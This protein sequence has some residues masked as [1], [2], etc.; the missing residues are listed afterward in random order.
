[1]I[2]TCIW[3]IGNTSQNIIEHHVTLRCMHFITHHECQSMTNSCNFH[4][5]KPINIQ[6][7]ITRKKKKKILFSMCL[8]PPGK[9]KHLLMFGTSPSL[10]SAVAIKHANW[11]WHYMAPIRTSFLM[12]QY[13]ALETLEQ[14]VQEI[15]ISIKSN[16]RQHFTAIDEVA[17]S[18]CVLHLS[19]WKS[20]K[21]HLASWNAL[22]ITA[23]SVQITRKILM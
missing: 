18:F 13:I 8:L 12:H 15:N 4:C 19:I 3:F 17:R 16:H 20:L 2:C 6:V 7:L 10:F 9:K 23:L 21:A 11:L 5:T 1:M 22:G 14:A